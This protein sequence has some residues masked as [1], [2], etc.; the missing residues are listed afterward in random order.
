[1]PMADGTLSANDIS[2]PLSLPE[3]AALRK[4][5]HFCSRLS[6]HGGWAK[7]FPSQRDFLVL[8]NLFESAVHVRRETDRSAH[9]SWAAFFLV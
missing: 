2:L 7:R 3:Y 5:G 8:S 9:P 6:V 1:M 4:R